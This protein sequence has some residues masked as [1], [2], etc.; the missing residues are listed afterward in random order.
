MFEL[1]NDGGA[2][3]IGRLLLPGSDDKTAVGALRQAEWNVNVDTEIDF[4]GHSLYHGVPHLTIR[5]T[6]FGAR[7]LAA[8]LGWRSL[9][10]RMVAFVW[11]VIE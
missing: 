5:M 9:L 10:R 4:I 8:G 11:L 6:L 2:I 7:Q 1:S 3:P